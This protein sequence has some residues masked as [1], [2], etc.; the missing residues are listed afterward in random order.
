FWWA[1]R[2]PAPR[3]R[4]LALACLLFTG[5]AVFTVLVPDVYQFSWRYELPVVITLVP[6]GVL[7][8]AALLS[9]RGAGRRLGGGPAAGAGE[10]PAG[11]APQ[12]GSLV[13]PGL[14]PGPAAPRPQAPRRW[15]L[16]GCAAPRRRPPPATPAT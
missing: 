4:Q 9:L 3:P 2:A 10:A 13:S 7:G 14:A 6:A 16:A 15:A 11:P 5:T 12:E 8:I 1:P